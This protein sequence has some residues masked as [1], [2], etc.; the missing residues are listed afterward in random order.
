MKKQENKEASKLTMPPTL[1]I[2]DLGKDSQELNLRG[3]WEH[4]FLCAS[5]PWYSGG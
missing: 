4:V 5:T 1:E 3:L 2:P